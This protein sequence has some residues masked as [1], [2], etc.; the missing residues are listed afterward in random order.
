M[1]LLDLLTC[2]GLASIPAA[3]NYFLDYCLGHPMSDTISTKAVLFRYSY[4]VAKTAL[5]LNKYQEIVR[6]LSQLLNSDD[7]ST[8]MQG[9]EQLKQAV[10][11]EGRKWFWFEQA[12][13][14]CPFCTNFWCSIIAAIIFCVTIPLHIFSPIVFFL[15]TPIFSHTI[16]R[17]L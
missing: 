3:F 5:P 12:L 13:G 4:W 15:F 14:M 10:M 16:L 11:I 9:R 17:K 2:V 1:V 6:H 8:R 7:L